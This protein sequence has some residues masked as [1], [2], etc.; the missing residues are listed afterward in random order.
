MQ[1]IIGGSARFSRLMEGQVTNEKITHP[2]RKDE[3]IIIAAVR[4]IILN[5]KRKPGRPRRN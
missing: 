5:G 1:H 4:W 2:T 3:S